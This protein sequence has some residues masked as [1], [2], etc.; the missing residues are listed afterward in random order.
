MTKILL[1]Y[2]QILFAE[3]FVFSVFFAAWALVRTIRPAPVSLRWCV[4]GIAVQF[5]LAAGFQCLLALHLFNL[6]GAAVWTLLGL[7]L[8]CSLLSRGDW[9]KFLRQPHLWWRWTRASLQRERVLLAAAVPVLAALAICLVRPAL[10]YDFLMYHGI[11]A[12]LWV[13]DGAMYHLPTPGN[14]SFYANF[15]AGGSVVPAWAMLLV[16]SDRLVSLASVLHWPFFVLAVYVL[17]RE[18]SLAPR[19]AWLIAWLLASLPGVLFFKGDGLVDIPMQSFMI[20]ATAFALH[21]LRRPD[22]GRLLVWQGAACGLAGAFKLTGLPV[23]AIL[24]ASPLLALGL[25]AIGPVFLRRWL[26][27]LLV[28]ALCVL[29]WNLYD[30]AETGAP[31][32]PFPIVVAGLHLGQTVPD[33][34]WYLKCLPQ[35][36]HSRPIQE[37]IALRQVFISNFPGRMDPFILPF[38]LIAPLGFVR[39]F[40]RQWRQAVLLVVLSICLAGLYASGSFTSIRLSHASINGRFFLLGFAWLAIL[41][42]PASA[43]WR[44]RADLYLV[45]VI[46]FELAA[47]AFYYWTADSLAVLPAVLLALLVA[48][49]LLCRRLHL[50]PGAWAAITGL[51]FLP[52]SFLIFFKLDDALRPQFMQNR[53][54]WKADYAPAYLAVDQPGHPHRI[55][56]TA[57]PKQAGEQTLPFLLVGRELQNRVFYV[58]ISRSGMLYPDSDPDRLKEADY[59]AWHQRLLMDRIDYV[60]SY[61]PASAELDWMHAHPEA[62]AKVAG[63]E[64]ADRDEAWGLYSVL[65][66]TTQD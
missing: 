50:A 8:G 64:G 1:L 54:D 39:L 40:Q 3:A 66:A 17:G 33:M 52:I 25:G 10:G 14:W 5:W 23:A 41:G 32:S 60:M 48:G 26:L 55:D 12:A 35:S 15:S 46:L 13:Q 30:I 51:A 65:P 37:L 45:A 43:L 44:R 31:F 47:F 36:P 42:Y 49:L 11:K 20:C 28:C 21:G 56:F 9:R 59:A 58:P 53:W 62:F 22:N 2:F 38:F 4:W 19:A 34:T 6:S 18:L 24:M 7:L 63:W 57:G 16:H 29:P 27:G 61:A